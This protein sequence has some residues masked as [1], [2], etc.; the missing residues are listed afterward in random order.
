MKLSKNNRQ[1]DPVSLARAL[2]AVGLLLHIGV[3]L[4]E[5]L[6]DASGKVVTSGAGECIEVAG[7]N[8]QVLPECGDAVK[9]TPNASLEA[10]ITD[11]AA[12]VTGQVMEKITIAA[13]ML[14]DFDS[15]ELSDDAKLIIDE[16]IQSL[17]GRAQLTSIMRVEGHTDSMGPTAYNQ[18]LS[19]QRAKAVADS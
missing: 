5:R 13:S 17:G 19:E 4:A 12:S 1:F 3:A 6:M 16:R 7:E 10:V 2:A 15:T 9:S 11:T 8:T 18:T 14:F